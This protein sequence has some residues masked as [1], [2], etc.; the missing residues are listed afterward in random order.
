MCKLSKN[1]LDQLNLDLGFQSYWLFYLE[2]L[3]DLSETPY[4]HFLLIYKD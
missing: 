2:S 3:V 1:P 4:D